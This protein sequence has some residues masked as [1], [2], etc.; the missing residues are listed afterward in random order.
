MGRNLGILTIIKDDPLLNSTLLNMLRE[1]KGVRKNIPPP[2]KPKKKE[3]E[4]QP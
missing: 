3:T 2:E 4:G 1:G